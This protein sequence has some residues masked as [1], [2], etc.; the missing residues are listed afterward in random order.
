MQTDAIAAIVEQWKHERPDLDPAP[1]LVTGR[2]FRLADELDQRL[3][4][5]FQAAGLGRGDFDVLAALRRSGDPYALSAGE[6][7]RTVLV[8]T[9]AITKR[10]DRLEARGL[11]G[12]SVAETDSRGRLITLT[13]EGVDVADELIAVHLDNQRRLL[14]GLS[15]DEQTQLAHLLERFAST[16]TP[17]DD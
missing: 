14:S 15:A 16:L 12:R 13:A 2:L 6:L 17:G 8:T 9:G 4:P 1:M 10:V 3:R 11:V 7:S 5:P